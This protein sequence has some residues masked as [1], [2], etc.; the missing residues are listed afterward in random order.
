MKTRFAVYAIY[1]ASQY[2]G[3]I[4][5]ESVEEAKELAEDMDASVT[6]CNEC[7]GKIDLGD[8]TKFEVDGE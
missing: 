4:E 3:T 5:A 1:T 6:L 2:L 8:V 7:A